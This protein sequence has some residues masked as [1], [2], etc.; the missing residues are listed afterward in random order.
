MGLI[1]RRHWT[2]DRS[3][4]SGQC[5]S[6]ACSH[7]LWRPQGP[8]RLKA[9][10][11]L[12]GPRR[13][14]ILPQGGQ[15]LPQG[16]VLE[17]PLSQL[18]LRLAE[19]LPVAG[20]QQ[21]RPA[22]QAQPGRSSLSRWAAHVLQ[23]SNAAAAAEARA[24][25]AGALQQGEPSRCFLS[26]LLLDSLCL[27]LH[28]VQQLRRGLLPPPE[29]IDLVAQVFDLRQRSHLVQGAQQALGTR[30]IRHVRLHELV[31]QGQGAGA[32]DAVHQA[33]PRALR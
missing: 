1:A 2:L 16:T 32:A 31:H 30:P 18:L 5:R 14:E 23:P 4:S 26:Q 13:Q 9:K 19:L 15:L 24:L 29:H 20:A 17:V 27:T 21:E 8:G 7:D 28:R 3:S 33:R 12:H 11:C 22:Q 6:R 10:R 25:A